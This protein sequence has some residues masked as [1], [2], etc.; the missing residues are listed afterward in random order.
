MSTDVA[1]LLAGIQAYLLTME[2]RFLLNINLIPMLEFS[3][4]CITNQISKSTLVLRPKEV[5]DPGEH[6]CG[7]SSYVLVILNSHLQF[8]ARFSS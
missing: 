8:I 4:Y 1:S 6:E 7:Q 3:I 5:Q 2:P